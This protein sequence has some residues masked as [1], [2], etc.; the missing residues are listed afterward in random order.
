M[1]VERAAGYSIERPFSRVHDCV[2]RKENPLSMVDFVNEHPGSER[3]GIFSAQQTLLECH[4]QTPSIQEKEMQVYGESTSSRFRDKFAGE[5]SADTSQHDVNKGTEKDSNSLLCDP[6]VLE[7]SSFICNKEEELNMAL[8]QLPD[9]SEFCEWEK[10]T[11]E[12][13]CQQMSNIHS[14]D[15]YIQKCVSLIQKCKQSGCATAAMRAYAHLCDNGVEVHG[16]FGSYLVAMFV[17][18]WSLPMAQQVF[19]RLLYRNHYSWTHLM[20][21][22]IEEGDPEN[23]LHLF[24]TMKEAG[25][26]PNNFTYVLVL[27]ACS[28]L[29]CIGKGQQIHAE[30]VTGLEEDL[31]ITRALLDFYV[32]CGLFPEACD[33][34]D[35]LQGHEIFLE[36]DITTLRRDHE[37]PATCV[38]NMTIPSGALAYVFAL[39]ACSSMKIL[40]RGLRLHIQIMK[41]GLDQDYFISNTLIGMYAKCGLLSEAWKL[42]NRMPQRDVVSWTALITGCIENGQ[43]SDAMKYLEMMGKE[44][45]SRNAFTLVSCFKGYG[46]T[47]GLDSGRKL[48]AQIMKEGL[49]TDFVICNS[50]VDMYAKCGSLEEA[51]IVFDKFARQ[52]IISWTSLIS[53]YTDH[54]LYGEA[55]DCFQ[56]MEA[57]GVAPN[58][59]AYNCCLKACAFTGNLDLGRKLHS[60]LVKE[61][62]ETHNYIG[63]ALAH[64][65]ARCGLHLD[66]KAIFDDLTGRDVI[67]WT[68]M[69]AELAEDGYGEQALLMLEQMHDEGL[70]PNSH[71][72]VCSL[73]AC[74][75]IGAIKRGRKLHIEVVKRGLEKIPFIT[76][77]LISMYGECGKPINI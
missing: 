3:N 45:V 66:A 16:D 68:L 64:M 44:G 76:K 33:V 48:H 22:Y 72:Y 31:C 61:E 65:Y 59:V 40:T 38:D 23:G 10:L 77:A 57:A 39:K 4:L 2:W 35:V 1:L 12:Q 58:T 42:L 67:S 14:C 11:I 54:G 20:Q 29:K 7:A 17:Q 47:Q 46:I 30:I 60:D 62:F 63:N 21:G 25:V 55:T 6:C 24:D 28:T 5:D 53:G 70:S 50:V 18:C 19:S 26:Y 34:F 8:L 36:E 27:R 56:K 43:C 74:G 52:D 41:E 32:K 73:K 71:T 69:I 15:S 13:V 51:R 49:Y 75:T 9:R 37:D